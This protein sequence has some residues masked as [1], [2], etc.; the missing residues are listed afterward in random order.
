[1]EE[2]FV[3]IAGFGAILIEMIAAMVIVFAVAQAAFG[4]AEWALRGDPPFQLAIRRV[5]LRLG[6]WLVLALELLLAADILATAVAPTWDDLAKLAVIIVLR[7][8]LNYFLEREIETVQR[9]E[10]EQERES[11]A[12]RS[13]EVRGS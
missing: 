4:L 1:M 3:R 9:H 7:T 2:H 8:T 10:R 5:R 11:A 13:Q 12:D 6:Q